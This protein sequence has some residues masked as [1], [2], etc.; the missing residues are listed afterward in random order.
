[1][2]ALSR[3]Y[4]TFFRFMGN[5]V[6]S[7]SWAANQAAMR[8]ARQVAWSANWRLMYLRTATFGQRLGQ[9]SKEAGEAWESVMDIGNVSARNAGM[10]A[11]LG[12]EAYLLF[13]VGEIIGRGSV[14][15]Y[16]V[17]PNGWAGDGEGGH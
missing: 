4:P 17:G 10:A 8:E 3:A 16:D 13:N 15:G 5:P 9:A 7:S 1:M 11:L 12:L 14:V 6:V 2:S